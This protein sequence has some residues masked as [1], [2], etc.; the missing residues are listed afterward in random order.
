MNNKKNEKGEKIE[1][2]PGDDAEPKPL[3][4]DSAG[5]PMNPESK[6]EADSSSLEENP[7]AVDKHPAPPKEEDPSKDDG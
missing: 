3:P 5:N 1:R 2:I 6:K 7:E 4:K